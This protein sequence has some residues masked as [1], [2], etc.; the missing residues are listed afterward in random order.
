MNTRILFLLLSSLVCSY[1][2]N[3]LAGILDF[4]GN[5]PRNL[6]HHPLIPARRSQDNIAEQ[7]DGATADD[8]KKTDNNT[9][10]IEEEE[11]NRQP[12]NL[13]RAG[14]NV[15]DGTVERGSRI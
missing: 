8:D 14:L 5:I 7:E 13:I 1:S 2:Q 11:V 10:E 3:R 6:P 4:L 15:V 9:S 12:A